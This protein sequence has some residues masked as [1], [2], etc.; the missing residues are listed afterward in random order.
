MGYD[1]TYVIAVTGSM[2]ERSI[3]SPQ[4]P[5][6]MRND[7]LNFG[8]IMTPPVIDTVYLQQKRTGNST[9]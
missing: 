1:K 9:E 4:V 2:D 3:I 6:N 8:P 5:I 7:K